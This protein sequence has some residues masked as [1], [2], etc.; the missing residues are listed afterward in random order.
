MKEIRDINLEHSSGI[1]QTARPQTVGA[2]FVFL[3][4]LER[5]AQA[6]PK[7]RLAQSDF[8]APDPEANTDMPVDHSSGPHV[9][10]LNAE[11]GS[12]HP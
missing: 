11:L 1:V 6:L 9:G 5:D 10:G 2:P 7:L 4:L 8:A 3:D 12:D